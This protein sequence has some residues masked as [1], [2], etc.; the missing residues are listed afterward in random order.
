MNAAL[1]MKSANSPTYMLDEYARRDKSLIS[2]IARPGSGPIENA[3]SSA[4]SV[5]KSSL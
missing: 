2:R 4:G 5:L 1:M 3:P